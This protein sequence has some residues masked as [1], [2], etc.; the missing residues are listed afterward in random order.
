MESEIN[1]TMK[2]L[3]CLNISESTDKTDKNEL[4]TLAHAIVDLRDAGSQLSKFCAK[5]CSGELQ[6]KDKIDDMMIEV[7]TELSHI[8]YHIADSDYLSHILLPYIDAKM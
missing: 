8:V 4:E 3:S 2:L 1:Q 6:T 7:Q 5:I